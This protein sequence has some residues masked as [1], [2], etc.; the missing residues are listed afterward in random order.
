MQVAAP[1]TSFQPAPLDLAEDTLY[2]LRVEAENILETIPALNNDVSFTTMIDCDG[3]LVHDPDEL[4]GN[5]CNSN[6]ILDT[7]DVVGGPF[8]LDSGP[9]S[10]IGFG[11]SQSI[12]IN[13]AR[14]S[15]GD[16]TLDFTARGDFEQVTERITVLINGVNAGFILESGTLC[17]VV[18][19][20][21]E[22][23][24]VPEATWD[25][26]ASS[27]TVLIQLVPSSGVNSGECGTTFIQCEVSYLSEAFS[28][29]SNGDGTPDECSVACSEADITTQGAGPRAR[30]MLRAG[31]RRHHRPCPIST[32]SSTRG[33]TETS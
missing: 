6:G 32:S 22:Q 2:Y 12:T 24:V 4:A 10:P 9:L 15:D 17:P 28:E 20:D 27:G 14:L 19:P 31:P 7:C 8:Y 29:D 21:T 5:D 30:S 33:R 25:V 11:S 16:V 1:T 26:A 23:L 13:N 3:N 18:T